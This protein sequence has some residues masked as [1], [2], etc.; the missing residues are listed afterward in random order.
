MK[1]TSQR[2]RRAKPAKNAV[3]RRALI[4]KF[5]QEF[6]VKPDAPTMDAVGELLRL[7]GHER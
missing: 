3:A 4:G 5:A 2:P 7:R 1:R 6:M